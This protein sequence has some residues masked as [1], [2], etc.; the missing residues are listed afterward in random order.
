MLDGED[1]IL[2]KLCLITDY[3]DTSCNNDIHTLNNVPGY[4]H[5]KDI[6]SQVM[7]NVILLV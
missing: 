2:D 5:N 4:T 1:T 7:E 3:S 6:Y